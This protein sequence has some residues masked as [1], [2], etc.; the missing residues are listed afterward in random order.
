MGEDR[1]YPITSNLAEISEGGDEH[2]HD[3]GDEVLR[4][5]MRCHA[6]SRGSSCVDSLR[7]KVRGHVSAA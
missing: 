4:R 3:Y 5:L 1:F 7:V 2:V 6:C